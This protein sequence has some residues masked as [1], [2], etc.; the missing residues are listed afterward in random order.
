MPRILI[1][2]FPDSGT[3][4]LCNMVNNLGFD[5][6]HSHELKWADEHNQWGYWEYRPIHRFIRSILDGPTRFTAEDIPDETYS[7]PMEPDPA[8][9]VVAI[10]DSVVVYKD[11]GIPLFYRLFSPD[12]KIIVIGRNEVDLLASSG[13]SHLGYDFTWE[14]LQRAHNKYYDLLSAMAKERDVLGVNYDAF[15]DDFYKEAQRV[16]DFLD[17]P[18]KDDLHKI[19]RP[20]RV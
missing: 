10:R 6:G 2:G 20:R 7:F 5:A 13:L 3:S 14:T 11:C 4:F 18:M 12:I 9:A 15:R 19:F 16:C 1:T 17:V 8:I